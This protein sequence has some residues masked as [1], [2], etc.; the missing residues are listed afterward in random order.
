MKNLLVKTL[1]CI[2]LV[3]P[4]GISTVSLVGCGGCTTSQ[5]TTSFNTLYSLEHTTTAAY[6]GYVAAIIKGQASTN[7]LPKISKAFN[8][9]Q[10]S[11]AVALDAVQNSTNALA[12]PNL[13]I[14]SQDLLNLI[15]QF[16][17]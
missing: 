4:V 13:V 11:M 3:A 10:A 5:Q 1:L 2:A 14:E 6:D 17:K 15:K 8:T 7:G 9:F 12:P 16:T